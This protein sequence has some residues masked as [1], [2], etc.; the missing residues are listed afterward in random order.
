MDIASI[1]TSPRFCIS[2]QRGEQE[3]NYR[4][5]GDLA[6]SLA[7]S[8]VSAA[9]TYCPKDLNAFVYIA[10]DQACPNERHIRAWPIDFHVAYKTTGMRPDSDLSAYVFL[11]NPNGGPF[12]MANLLARP[13]GCRRPPSNFGRAVTLAS[14]WI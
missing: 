5:V 8:A 11:P 6:R 7:N 4:A 13:F 3:R 1:V 9:E 2:E 10:R 14:S 12:C